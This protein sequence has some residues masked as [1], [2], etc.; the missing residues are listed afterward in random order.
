[1]VLI[2]RYIFLN[3]IL[4][5]F[6]YRNCIFSLKNYPIVGQY[7]IMSESAEIR[8]HQVGKICHN[9]SVAGVGN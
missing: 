2:C 5:N 8:S 9:I 6:S 3:H 1:M 7:S 4:S